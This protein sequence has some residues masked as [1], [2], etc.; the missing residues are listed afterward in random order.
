VRVETREKRPS[1][2]EEEEERARDKHC[3]QGERLL[4]EKIKTEAAREKILAAEIF[5]KFFS[6]SLLFSFFKPKIADIFE[7]RFLAM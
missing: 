5:F 3:E 6:I 1:A 4:Q 7:S 2:R